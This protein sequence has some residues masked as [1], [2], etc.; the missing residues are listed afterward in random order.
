MPSL[1]TYI[2]EDRSE[3]IS[4]WTRDF[5]PTKVGL[6]DGSSA[7]LTGS[8]SCDE[9]PEG[10]FIFASLV[11][12]QAMELAE[13]WWNDGIPPF[14]DPVIAQQIREECETL[15]ELYARILYAVT[16]EKVLVSW[17]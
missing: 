4:V 11:R 14:P 15:D 17:T 9:P 16:D 10:A 12:G 7:H 8:A 13:R 2:K 6:P 3:A 5:T 1:L